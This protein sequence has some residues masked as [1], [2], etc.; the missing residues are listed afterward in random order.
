MDLPIS[1]DCWIPSGEDAVVNRVDENGIFAGSAKMDASGSISCATMKLTPAA[2]FGP[3]LQ[4]PDQYRG[5]PGDGGDHT[6]D[7][8]GSCSQHLKSRI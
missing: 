4:P 3:G 5:T 1:W 6:D 7:A 8:S 2:N